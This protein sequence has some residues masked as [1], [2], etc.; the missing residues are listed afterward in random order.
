MSSE[1]VE[2]PAQ[3]DA[4][5][6]ENAFDSNGPVDADEKVDTDK[7]EESSLYISNLTRFICFDVHF[8]LNNL[9]FIN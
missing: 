3:E 5:I 1:A 9:F 7:G 2:I 6:M 8:E 4:P